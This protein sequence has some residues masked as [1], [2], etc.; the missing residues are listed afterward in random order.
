MI[1]FYKFAPQFGMRDASP[2]VLKL[3]TYLRLAG[4]AYNTNLVMDPRKAPKGKL[5]YIMDDGK[6]IA[7]SSLC[8]TYLKDKYGDPLGEDLSAEQ[9]AIGHAVK[10]ML[11]ERTYWALVNHRWMEDKNALIIRDIWFGAIPAFMRGFVFG[12]IVKDMKKGMYAHGIGRHSHAEIY[13]FALQDLKAVEDILGNT[14]YLLGKT[15]SEYDASTYGLLANFIAKPF[16]S[17]MSEYIG[18]SKTL[19]GYI[20]RVNKKAFG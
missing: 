4:I 8:I 18:N 1:E 6:T 9:H 7:D 17:V 15:P 19:G 11:E 13:G 5:P 16:P 10:T 3:E 2:F 20:A 14:P 12:K